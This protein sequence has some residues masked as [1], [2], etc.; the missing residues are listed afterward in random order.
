MG[1]L[2]DAHKKALFTLFALYKIK[3]KNEA[4]R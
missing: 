3:R 2:L 1:K 4:Q